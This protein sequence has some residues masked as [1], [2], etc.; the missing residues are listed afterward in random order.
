MQQYLNKNEI[1]EKEFF[2]SHIIPFSKDCPM[3]KMFVK[4][5]GK[6]QVLAIK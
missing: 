6:T 4:Q 2:E 1:V 5:I 3:V